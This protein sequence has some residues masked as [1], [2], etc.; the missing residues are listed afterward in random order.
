M[1]SCSSFAICS[2]L[3]SGAALVSAAVR[4]ARSRSSSTRVASMSLSIALPRRNSDCSSA[5]AAPNESAHC[6]FASE[7]AWHC[8]AIVSFCAFEYSRSAW[9]SSCCAF[10]TA[11]ALFFFLL[12]CST[13]WCARS[14]DSNDS[15]KRPRLSFAPTTRPWIS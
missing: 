14:Y 5:N 4:S 12:C 1:R 13:F 10:T 3:S 7:H 8:A 9:S 6:R 15:R 11:A 2:A